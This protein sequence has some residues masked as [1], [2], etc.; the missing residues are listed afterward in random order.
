MVWQGG[1]IRKPS[2]GRFRSARNKKK[3]EG[4]GEPAETKIGERR[5]TMLRTRGANTKV[6]L[7]QTDVAN[8]YNP[9]T[10][11]CAK[12]KIITVVENKANPHFVRRNIITQRAIIQT[13][14]GKAVVTNRPGQE[15]CVNAKLILE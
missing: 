12:S 15:G 2:G 3:F 4:G 8:V 14:L 10:N 6:R 9:K 7:L 5:A 13:E 1:S 11:K